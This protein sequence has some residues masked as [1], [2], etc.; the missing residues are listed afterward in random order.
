MKLTGIMS[1]ISQGGDDVSGND[2]LH[3][4]FTL[5]SK[6]R[7]DLMALNELINR[8]FEERFNI[9]DL[10]GS[11]A[12]NEAEIH[13]QLKAI[14]KA[15]KTHENGLKR[16]KRIT[17][18]FSGDPVQITNPD[19]INGLI[20]VLGRLH[21]PEGEP[22]KRKP[23]QSDKQVKYDFIKGV[24]ADCFQLLEAQGHGSLSDNKKLHFAGLVLAVLG[25][26]PEK[27]DGRPFEF[28]PM[29]AF[30]HDIITNLKKHKPPK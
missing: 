18:G 1:I 6:F 10:S 14:A 13:Q 15:V 21:T 8:H 20:K 9:G 25:V 29:E 3:C 24:V 4:Y 17:L 2:K 22:A 19:L 5:V 23:G 28:S 11:E 27:T 12:R 7:V 26:L 30:K 16:V